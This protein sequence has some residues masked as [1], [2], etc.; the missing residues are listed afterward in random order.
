[1]NDKP[2]LMEIAKGFIEKRGRQAVDKARVEILNSK[3]DGG[4]VSSATKY[5]AKFILPKG[6]PVFPALLSISSECVG[7]KSEK[8]PSIGAALILI[9][10][11]ADIH[12]D[13]IDE[14]KIKYSKQ[15]VYGKF[16]PE[17]ATLAGDALLV[18][19]ITLLNRECEFLNQN[20][21][22]TIQNLFL[23]AFFDISKAEANE[24]TFKGRSDISAEEYFEIINIKAAVPEVHCKIGAILGNGSDLEVNFLGY[25]GK[26]LGIISIIRDEFV[27]L[28]EFP[29]LSNRLK[30]ECLP[31]PMLY[32]Q[33]N[34]DLERELRLAVE[35]SNFTKKEATKIA[36]LV[37]KCKEV[38]EL[39]SKIATIV[40]EGL[41]SVK[42]LENNPL[43]KEIELLLLAISN[44]F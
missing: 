35:R 9:A 29:E 8:V 41:N 6:L 33:K 26:S 31:L 18:Q 14:S 32:A 20:R 22:E 39:R 12:D 28:F 16:G 17:I 5:F 15:T 30:N 40:Q 24:L 44:G 21:K 11:A 43:F 3:Y 36:D 42:F 13:I 23:E 10:A 37:L 34:P 25:Y 7:G 4:M 38:E 27:D 19:G 1:M 2:E